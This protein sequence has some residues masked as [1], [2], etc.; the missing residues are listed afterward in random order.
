[1]AEEK[2]EMTSMM[3]RLEVEGKGCGGDNGVYPFRIHGTKKW[4]A[5]D[6]SK[7]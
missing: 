6:T 2:G 7:R 1:M 4:G 3:A 5:G